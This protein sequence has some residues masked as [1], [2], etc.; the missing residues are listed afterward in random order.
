[1]LVKMI[2]WHGFCLACGCAASQLDAM[3]ENLCL[4]TWIL[5]GNF[6][7]TQA[8]GISAILFPQI[9]Y[10]SDKEKIHFVFFVTNQATLSE[11]PFLPS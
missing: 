8:P 2:F 3:F 10:C 9:N 6:L 1:M 11:T 5:H 7:V 4:L